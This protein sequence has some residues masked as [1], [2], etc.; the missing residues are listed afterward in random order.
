[1]GNTLF[2]TYS[3]GENRVT[4]SIIAV[5]ERVGISVLTRIFK[6]IME[7]PEFLLIEFKNQVKYNRSIPDAQIKAS[8]NFLIETKIVKSDFK[9][10]LDEHIKHVK[11]DAK[12]ILLTPH[13]NAPSEYEK[14]SPT[15]KKKVL[16]LNFDKLINIL[17]DIINDNSIMINERDK[18]LL[19]ELV[20]FII[21]ENLVSEPFENKVLV[22]PSKTAFPFYNKY[23]FYRCQIDRPFTL[24]EY[25]AFYYEAAIQMVIPK[26]LAYCDRIDLNSFK[27]SQVKWEKIPDLRRDRAGSNSTLIFRYFDDKDEIIERL[28]EIRNEHNKNPLTTED[29]HKILILSKPDDSRTKHIEDIIPN[30]LRSKNGIT[31]AFVQNTRYTN[32]HDLLKAKFTS[33]LV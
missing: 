26:I 20:D 3:K 32:L 18:F 33:D 29:Y 11:G 21:Q 16:W 23:Y 30:N 12:L 22:V 19:S 31:A 24:T 14:L 9:K 28:E 25:I 5:L 6:G 2:S 15:R 10:Q 8:F 17:E 4:S 27:F 1:M 13:Y 7:D